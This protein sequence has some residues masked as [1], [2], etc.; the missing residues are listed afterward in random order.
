MR[1]IPKRDPSG[2]CIRD[3]IA[4]RRI[5]DKRC[6]CGETRSRAFANRE[7][8]KCVECER[9][10]RGHKVTDNH[11]VAGRANDPTT[12]PIRVNDHRARLS[13]DQM[14]WPEETL[15]N[16]DGSPILAVAASIRGFVDTAMYL[17]E[18][19]LKHAAILEAADAYL[20]R[21]LGR[22]WWL[23]TDLKHL[24]PKR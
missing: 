11:H 22:K 9:K 8:K 23:K 6:R 19:Q 1:K 17:L 10:Q 21:T 13:V 14:D 4:A 3:E 15:E 24:A 18:M 16:S 20:I 12:I 5:G 2:A 7:S